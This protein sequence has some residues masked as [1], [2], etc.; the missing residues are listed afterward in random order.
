MYFL[1]GQVGDGG[2]EVVEVDIVLGFGGKVVGWAG[3]GGGREGVVLEEGLLG[4]WVVVV[5][6]VDRNRP[7][8][9]WL[10]F[11][12]VG[13]SRSRGIDIRRRRDRVVMLR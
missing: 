12:R 9:I 4:S 11:L 1:I 2:G 8:G 5:V 6:M 10:D 13:R 7:V 3:R